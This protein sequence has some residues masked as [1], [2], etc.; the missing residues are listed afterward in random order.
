MHL[1]MPLRA[2]SENVESA[3]CRGVPRPEGGIVQVRIYYFSREIPNSAQL[4]SN[5]RFDAE[6]SEL[7]VSD[8]E[9]IARHA[10]D[11]P[12]LN[13]IDFPREKAGLYGFN[14]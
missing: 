4:R 10:C 5:V 6:I 12:Q 11:S 9:N 7:L 2:A 13:R 3:S 8:K 14:T 1:I